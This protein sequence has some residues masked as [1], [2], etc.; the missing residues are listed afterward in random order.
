M[1]K[2]KIYVVIVLCLFFTLSFISTVLC[3]EVQRQGQPADYPDKTHLIL[4]Q[5]PS[6]PTVPP[7]PKTPPKPQ[8]LPQQ[9][10]Q[11]SAPQPAAPQPQQSKSSPTVS[12]FFDDADIFEVVQTIFADVLKVNYIIDPRV[13]GRVNFRTVTPIPKDEVLSVMEIIFRLNGIGFVQE[14]GLYRIV[15]LTEVPQE[16]L[17]SQIGKSPGQVAIEM[18][19]FK[20]LDLKES[21]PDIENALGLHIKG[22]TVRIL[23]LYRLN[24]LIV[25]ASSKVQLEYIKQWVETFDDMFAVARPKIFVYP[26]QNGKADHVA[27]ILQSILGAPLA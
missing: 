11:P 2:L 27:Q 7:Q 26:L 8:V 1:K 21:M 10:P 22:G 24:A 6:Q 23:P 19:T 15:P 13:K 3:Q 18:F 20:N 16:L 9:A 5:V 17:Y 12:F 25:I 14:G 4:A